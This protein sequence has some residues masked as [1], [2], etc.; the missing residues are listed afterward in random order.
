MKQLRGRGSKILRKVGI[1][2]CYRLGSMG[3]RQAMDG[4]EQAREISS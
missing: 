3:Q 4:G 2:A 1:V